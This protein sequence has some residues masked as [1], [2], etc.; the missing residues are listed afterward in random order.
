MPRAKKPTHTQPDA[1]D[2]DNIRVNQPYA[3]SDDAKW[4]GFLNARLTQDDVDD[5][6]EWFQA[7]Q[8][9]SGWSLLHS[10]LQ[11]GIKLSV[12]YDVGNNT[13]IATFTGDLLR[14]G[15][16]RAVTSRAPFWAQAVLLA[17]YKHVVMLKGDYSSLA[18]EKPKWN[19]FG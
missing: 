4:G 11:Q 17:V 6:Q 8:A 13:F 2:A 16:R 1:P 19:T 10:A 14:I 7:A 3:C 18:T 15:D 9:E 12:T 5:F